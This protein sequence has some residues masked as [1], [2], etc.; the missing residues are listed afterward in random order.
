MDTI[1]DPTLLEHAPPAPEGE[2]FSEA[3][4]LFQRQLRRRACNRKGFHALLRTAFG[5]AYDVR[6]ADDYRRASL[7]GDWS[8]LPAIR[9]VPTAVLRGALGAYDPEGDVVYLSSGLRHH[10][11]LA[12]STLAEEVGHCLDRRLNAVETPGDEGAVFRILLLGGALSADDLRRLRA[13]DD[14]GT[15]EVEGRA[16]AVELRSAMDVMGAYDPTSSNADEIA[17]TIANDPELFATLTVEQRA[18][19]VRGLFDGSTSEA[20]EDAALKLLVVGT[21][22]DELLQLVN[23]VGGWDEIRDEL[24]A[25]DMDTIAQAL[26]SRQTSV[27][28]E[29]FASLGL[30]DHANLSMEDFLVR[31]ADR[32]AGMSGPELQELAA[33]LLGPAGD[34]APLLDAVA[35]LVRTGESGQQ[36]EMLEDLKGLVQELAAH[37]TGEVHRDLVELRH[38]IAYTERVVEN[39]KVGDYVSLVNLLPDL[40]D[41]Q[42]E[43]EQRQALRETLRRFEPETRAVEVLIEAR[44]D[45]EQRSKLGRFMNAR[46]DALD[47]FD[48]SGGAAPR[49]GDLERYLN[50]IRGVADT[51]L[52]EAA[53][54]RKMFALA[55]SDVT[56]LLDDALGKVFGHSS[57][58]EARGLVNLLDSKE[59]RAGDTASLLAYLPFDVKVR[60]IHDMIDTGFADGV[61]EDDEQAILDVLRETAEKDPSEFFRLINAVGYSKLDTHINGEEWDDF[62]SLL[63]RATAGLRG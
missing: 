24:D 37:V 23:A 2:L 10:P 61:L 42:L 60:L 6:K 17:Q 44:G 21:T 36:S 63:D 56:G 49:S 22:K 8:W 19:L 52:A 46:R 1:Q 11:E 9:V 58:D 16:I 14:W 38:Q 32:I 28:D 35:Q 27:V 7:C 39:L 33:R 41:P 26:A 54:F 51:A 3:R 48:R 62:L 40:F 31:V 20:E 53:D 25:C 59:G 47:L 13:E 30:A 55:V 50:G 18:Q 34:A 57:D 43:K 45:V 12:A 5:P 15:I 29:L 4:A